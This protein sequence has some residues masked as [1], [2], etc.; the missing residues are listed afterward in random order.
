MSKRGDNSSSRLLT[1]IVLVVA[2]FMANQTGVLAKAH[3]HLPRLKLGGSA[4][5]YANPIGKSLI[6]WRIDQ[7]VDYSGPGSLYAVGSGTI[8]NLYDSGWPGGTFLEL[9]LD[10]GRYKGRYVYYAE[11]VIPLV[12]LGHVSK[13]QLIARLPA[14]THCLEIG[15]AHGHESLARALGQAS[16]GDAEGD[17]G[18][19]PTACGMR[20]SGL[21]K[22]LGGKPGLVLSGP[23]QGNSC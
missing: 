17:A 12:G 11:A 7:G 21:I 9:H 4:K 6:P 5:G 8:V 15:W 3:L 13:G 18:R 14:C 1:F 10:G 19:Y 2:V 23:V 16:A 20:F 22:S